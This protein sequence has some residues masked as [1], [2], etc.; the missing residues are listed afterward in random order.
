MIV[1]L[2]CTDMF[3]RW[4]QPNRYLFFKRKLIGIKIR[5][6]M[7]EQLRNWPPNIKTNIVAPKYSAD[8][9]YG[10]ENRISIGVRKKTNQGKSRQLTDRAVDFVDDVEVEEYYEESNLYRVR[11]DVDGNANDVGHLDARDLVLPV[12][13]R[14]LGPMKQQECKSA[15]HEYRGQLF[16]KNERSICVNEANWR[17]GTER[18]E[19]KTND[20]RLPTS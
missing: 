16:E 15:K 18:N 4:C 19:T 2:Q 20:L 9:T 12:L 10:S 14:D 5:D 13:E 7:N 1:A 17:T 6:T 3:A 11:H 8:K